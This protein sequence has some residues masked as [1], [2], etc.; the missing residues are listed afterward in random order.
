[1]TRKEPSIR[2]HGDDRVNQ[3]RLQRRT[4]ASDHGLG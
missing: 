4:D 2:P 1:M 3:R